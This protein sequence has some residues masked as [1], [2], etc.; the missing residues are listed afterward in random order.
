MSRCNR[1]FRSIWGDTGSAFRPRNDVNLCARRLNVCWN[2]LAARDI[3]ASDLT[4]GR[5]LKMAHA[6]IIAQNLMSWFSYF[7]WQKNNVH[8][9]DK[10]LLCLRL[11]LFHS[12]CF[13]FYN[14]SYN[15]LFKKIENFRYSANWII[16]VIK[17]LS[18]FLDNR[19]ERS[20]KGENDFLKF[21][22]KLSIRL[23]RMYDGEMNCR[24]FFAQLIKPERKVV[25][26]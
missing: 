4:R 21:Q 23:T 7:I 20:L 17:N 5:A 18:C 11:I 8:W 19:F 3:S 12:F 16:N 13:L 10:V 25:W 14:N 1:E 6:F 15:K 2:V 24:R 26:Q 22:L 9:Y